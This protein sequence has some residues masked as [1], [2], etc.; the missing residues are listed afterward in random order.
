MVIVTVIGSAFSVLVGP[1]CAISG[2]PAF[3]QVPPTAGG[4]DALDMRRDG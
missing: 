1:G 3:W 2:E 4:P